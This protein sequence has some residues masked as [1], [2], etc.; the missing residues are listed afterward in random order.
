MKKQSTNSL[1]SSK[2][3]NKTLKVQLPEKMRLNLADINFLQS[4]VGDMAKQIEE[5]E[6]KEKYEDMLN[7]VV[8]LEEKFTYILKNSYETSN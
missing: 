6:E 1:K 7:Y 2:K 5:N 8:R 4:V 3:E